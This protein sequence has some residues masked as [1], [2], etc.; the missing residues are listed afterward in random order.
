MYVTRRVGRVAYL[1]EFVKVADAALLALLVLLSVT[2]VLL[3]LLWRYI[4]D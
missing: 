2:S 1:T 3:N 4:V